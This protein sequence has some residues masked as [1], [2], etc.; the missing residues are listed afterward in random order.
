M[1]KNNQVCES[2]PEWLKDI[3]KNPIL[4]WLQPALN[5]IY[6]NVYVFF[7]EFTRLFISMWIEAN[8][9]PQNFLNIVMQKFTTQT[10]PL[11]SA[12]PASN[13]LMKL[14]PFLHFEMASIIGH[15]HANTAYKYVLKSMTT[16]KFSPKFYTSLQARLLFDNKV[17]AWKRPEEDGRVVFEIPK[18]T[19]LNN[20]AMLEKI[21]FL[22]LETSQPGVLFP[23]C[24]LY[25]HDTRTYI[26]A[27]D[28]QFT[29]RTY[30]G[31]G[32]VEVGFEDMKGLPNPDFDYNDAFFR[33]KFLGNKMYWE[34]WNGE[35]GFTHSYFIM[36][37]KICD[38]P[39]RS[40]YT[41]VKVAEGYLDLNTYE[42]KI[43]WKAY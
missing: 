42:V 4:F 8:Q 34:V 13:L 25:V 1:R 17:M 14:N 35:H 20:P 26:S 40:E 7:E 21:S 30:L 43:T 22:G 18:Q 2:L 9:D 38:L 11:I 6:E 29:R 3:L 31:D 15:A 24:E 27:N 37:V 16:P 33:Y 12:L 36:G 5:L 19:V 28:V 32:W 39:P 10:F 41:K 23:E